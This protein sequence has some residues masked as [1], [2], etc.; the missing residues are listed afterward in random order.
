MIMTDEVCVHD[1]EA[2]KESFIEQ[3]NG[4]FPVCL[5]YAIGRLKSTEPAKNWIMKQEKHRTAKGVVDA[6]FY[7]YRCPVCN[8]KNYKQSRYCPDCG[9]RLKGESE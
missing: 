2:I 6:V 5:E 3:T 1:L 4:S 7:I 9:E 8:G